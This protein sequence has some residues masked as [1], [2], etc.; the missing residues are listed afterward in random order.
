MF[1]MALEVRRRWL[2]SAAAA[3]L[4]VP[5][6][7]A[8]ARA[9]DPKPPPGGAKPAAMDGN[10]ADA[11]AEPAK[12]ANAKPA[13]LEAIDDAKAAPLSEGLKKAMRMRNAIEALPA[14][15][16][17][18]KV[19]N[20]AFEPLLLK[21]TTHLAKDVAIRAAQMLADRPSEKLVGSL[22]RQGWLASIN[23][24]RPEVRGAILA[25]LGRLGAKLDAKQYDEVESLWRQAASDEILIGIAKFFEAAKTDKRPCR[26]FAEFLDEPRAGNVNDG[27][28]PPAGYWETRWKQ[29]Q[30]VLP[31]V[32]D[33]LHAITGQTFHSTADAKAWFQANEK[34][35]G[36]KW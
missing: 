17:I 33:A 6:G 26:L 9:D 28:N 25:T 22:W 12:E 27:S 4:T 5:F 8:M 31:A 19:T 32:N 20:P 11:P 23:D 35:F 24:K 3:L 21:L 34:T 30:A 29:W 1:A 7:V 16:A 15:E 36:F 10:P 13:P 18:A 2:A 14:L